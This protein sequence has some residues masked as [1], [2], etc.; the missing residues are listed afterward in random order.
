MA[1]RDS[2]P[3]EETTGTGRR[4]RSGTLQ[5]QVYRVPPHLIAC[6]KT[7]KPALTTQRDFKPSQSNI[8]RRHWRIGNESITLYSIHAF[9]SP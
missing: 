1:A 3:L 4:E 5:P 9:L 6:T 7:E 2:E 8:G